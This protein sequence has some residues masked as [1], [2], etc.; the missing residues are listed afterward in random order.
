LNVPGFNGILIHRGNFTKD[1]HGCILVGKG[2][3]VDKISDS[4]TTEIGLVNKLKAEKGKIIIKVY[5][6]YVVAR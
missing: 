1:T 6:S 4:A 2:F 3:S 5:D